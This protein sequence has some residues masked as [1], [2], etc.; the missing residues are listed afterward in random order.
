M[1]RQFEKYIEKYSLISNGD[2]IVIAVS[3]GVDSM[4]L[5]H[6]LSKI[7]PILNLRVTVA[8]VNHNLRGS[9]SDKDEKFVRNASAAYKFNYYSSTWKSPAKKNIQDAARKFRYDF[10]MKTASK[11]GANLIATAHHMDDQ[12]ETIILQIS[13]G[14]GLS[15]LGGIPSCTKINK[16]ISIVRPM[17]DFSRRDIEKYA[18]NFRVDYRN[19][20]SN[21][22]TKYKR[23]KIRH[24][25]IPMLE[26]INPKIKESLSAIAETARDT[27]LTIN[28]ITKQFAEANFKIKN[29]KIIWNRPDFIELPDELRCQ[30]IIEA[31]R[32]VK[33]DKKD[34]NYDQIKHI[35]QLSIGKNKKSQYMLPKN[36]RFVRDNDTLSIFRL[37]S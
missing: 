19:D 25:V 31:F 10:L 1:F 8:H 29:K 6:M 18:K 15:G 22:K 2:R 26:L 17:L 7:C 36:Y 5:L 30:I 28:F 13:R 33:G 24:E 32:S 3:G 14:T 35:D 21:K 9:A 12:A 37:T 4:V 27:M 23:N 16:T 20:L 34:L 11:V